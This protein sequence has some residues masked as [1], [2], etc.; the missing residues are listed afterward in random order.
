MNNEIINKIYNQFY[1]R[2]KL[3]WYIQENLNI[4]LHL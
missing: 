1:Y 2:I 3:I 4:K